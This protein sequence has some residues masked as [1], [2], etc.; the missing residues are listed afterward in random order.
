VLP[1]IRGHRPAPPNPCSVRYNPLEVFSHVGLAGA[2]VSVSYSDPFSFPI[3]PGIPLPCPLGHS[4]NDPPTPLRGAGGQTQFSVVLLWSPPPFSP[5]IHALSFFV[6]LPPGNRWRPITFRFSPS[7]S[8]C[9]RRLRTIFFL[10]PRSFPKIPRQ[11]PPNVNSFTVVPR[12]LR[13]H[14]SFQSLCRL[15]WVFGLSLP[16]SSLFPPY[17]LFF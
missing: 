15:T 1:P 4:P 14:V 8:R 17:I 11:P 12:R 5:M 9:A 7:P 3:L 16:L 10:F 6:F 13:V 2:K